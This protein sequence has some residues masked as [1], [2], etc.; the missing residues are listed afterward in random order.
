MSSTDERERYQQDFDREQL[1][2][3]R[4]AEARR[5]LAEATERAIDEGQPA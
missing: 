1:V 2:R 3:Q 4:I 5:V